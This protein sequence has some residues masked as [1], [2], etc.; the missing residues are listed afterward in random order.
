MQMVI[1]QIQITDRESK[2]E[3]LLIDDGYEYLFYFVNSFFF[4]LF[5]CLEYA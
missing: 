4:S 5:V 1:E 2:R 3:L